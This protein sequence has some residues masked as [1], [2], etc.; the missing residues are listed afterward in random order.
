MFSLTY[1][2]ILMVINSSQDYLGKKKSVTFGVVGV[3]IKCFS[4][5]DG[6]YHT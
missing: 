4:P 6:H 3:G 5:V 1:S 2:V